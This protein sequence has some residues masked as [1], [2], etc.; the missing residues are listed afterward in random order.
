[1]AEIV[2]VEI[3]VSLP[4]FSGI[5]GSSIWLWVMGIIL[6]GIL[7]G[8]A[9]VLMQRFKV[10]NK[11][12]VVFENISGQ[13]YQPVFKDRAKLVKLGDAGEE[14]LYLLKKKVFRSA[15]GRKMGKNTYWFAVGQDGYWYNCL[16]GDLDSK[17]G[18]LDIEPIDRDLRYMHVAIRKNIQ[19]RY[20]K[21]SMMEKYG[22]MIIGGLL[23]I[24]FIIG[25]WFLLNKISQI[26]DGTIETVRASAELQKESKN[27]IAAI[28]NLV[29]TGGGSGLRPA[30]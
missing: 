13:G 12:I 20:K 9:L 25:A 18:M 26:T 16:L 30:G 17:L 15:Y 24:I 22:T 2:G 8:V 23:V 1:M 14:L 4:T 7:G 21:Q 28:E 6:I 19:D 10:Y 11:R 29:N 5:F 3:P 27:L